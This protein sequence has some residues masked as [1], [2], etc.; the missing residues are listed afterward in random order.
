MEYDEI[1]KHCESLGY[2]DKFR[3]SQLLIQLARKEEEIQNPQTRQNL[4]E[5]VTKKISDEPATD[6]NSI[7]YVIDRLAKLRPSKKKSLLNSIAAMY[8]FQGAISEKDQEMIVQKLEQKKFL[9]VDSNNRVTY[10]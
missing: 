5:K 8:Q 4:K 9:K 1:A 10:F 6:I 2:R 7:Q 3:L